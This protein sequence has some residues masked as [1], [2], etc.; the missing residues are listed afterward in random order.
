MDVNWETGI[1]FASLTPFDSLV[2]HTV[3]SEYQISLL[4]TMGRVLVRGGGRCLVEPIE[5]IVYGVRPGLARRA[6]WIGIGAR[7]EFKF[8]NGLI[9][10]SPVSLIQINSCPALM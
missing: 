1:S 8:K 6:G 10:T 2:V 9:R 4:D 3:N 5:A 7:L